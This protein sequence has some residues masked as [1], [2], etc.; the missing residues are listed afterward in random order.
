MAPKPPDGSN[1]AAGKNFELQQA[2]D[3][4]NAPAPAQL[5][6]NHVTEATP[7]SRKSTNAVNITATRRIAQQR[8]GATSPRQQGEAR[9]VLHQ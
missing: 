4:G 5:N 7:A 8:G 3:C 6:V 1:R 2:N 9:Y